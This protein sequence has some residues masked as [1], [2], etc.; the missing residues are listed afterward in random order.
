MKAIR[1]ILNPIIFF[2]LALLYLYLIFYTSFNSVEL[3]KFVDSIDYQTI[4]NELDNEVKTYVDYNSFKEIA[5]ETFIDI[6]KGNDFDS[7]KIL[8][9]VDSKLAIFINNPNLPEEIKQ[10]IRTEAY[11]KV[12][13]FIEPIDEFTKSE[14]VQTIQAV[15]QVFSK[16]TLKSILI[17]LAVILIMSLV[18][19][20]K[21][22]WIK[23]NGMI[24]GFITITYFIIFLVLNKIISLAPGNQIVA[25]VKSC[26]NILFESSFYICIYFMIVSLLSLIIYK[27]VLSKKYMRV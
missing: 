10:E 25:I 5:S 14:S 7:S 3:K 15:Y 23:Y 27:F 18:I 13:S 22:K 6:L 21:F 26:F 12:N 19:N 2:C 8:K 4:Y 1:L 24:L 11:L 16:E 20:P 17:I 9:I